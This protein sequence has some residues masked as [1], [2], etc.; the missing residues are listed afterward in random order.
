MDGFYRH[1]FLFLLRSKFYESHSFA[2]F[3][4]HPFVADRFVFVCGYYSFMVGAPSVAQLEIM[5]DQAQQ[6]QVP[7]YMGFNKNVSSYVQLTQDFVKKST[8]TNTPKKLEVTFL[9][10]NNYAPTPTE[11][12][13][14]FERNA[15][16]MLKNML[17]HELAICVTF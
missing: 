10:N 5:R 11:L 2:S 17:I 14:C 3:S 13:E 4:D 1:V 8:S 9:H 16:G 6:A 7:V 15:E 12:A